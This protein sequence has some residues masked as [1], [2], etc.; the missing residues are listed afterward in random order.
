MSGIMPKSVLPARAERE[1]IPADLL[2]LIGAALI[3][4]SA[5]G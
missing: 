4:A 2:V 5:S 1:R 3:V